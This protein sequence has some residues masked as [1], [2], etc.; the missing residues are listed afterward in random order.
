MK[1]AAAQAVL[2]TAVEDQED[3]EEAA[4]KAAAALAKESDAKASK[5]DMTNR[6]TINIMGTA[7]TDSGIEFFGKVRIRGGNEGNGA[8]SGSSISAPRVGA[9][10]GGLTV[11]VGNINGAID[12]L[13]GMLAGSVGLTGLGYSNNTTGGFD[14][15]GFSSGGGGVNG[16]EVI[17]SANG[18]GVHLSHSDQAAAARTALGINYAFGDWKVA[19]GIQESDLDAEDFTTINVTGAIGSVSVGASYSAMHS[20]IGD[21]IR[22]NAGFEAG[23][24]TNV[25]IYIADTDG[26]SDTAYGLGFT[27]SLGGATLAGG[28]ASNNIGTTSADLGVRFKF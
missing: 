23:A 26:A 28:I 2:A 24:G 13:P 17:Y 18:L 10:M 4:S 8:T 16:V 9:T 19:M 3:L 22:V 6:F 7:E 21:G 11:A 20:S 12:S 1:D 5:T 14:Y 25:T 27:H 15:D